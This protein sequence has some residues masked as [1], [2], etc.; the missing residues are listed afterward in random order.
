MDENL[1]FNSVLMFVKWLVWQMAFPGLVC[2]RQWL[3]DFL[4]TS[5]YDRSV[6]M[7]ILNAGVI[8][9]VW[10]IVIEIQYMSFQD[11]ANEGRN[12]VRARWL[13]GCRT[14]N[15]DRHRTRGSSDRE[16]CEKCREQ[17]H[18]IEVW[19]AIKNN[20]LMTTGNAE[21]D[22]RLDKDCLAR[23]D[24]GKTVEFF[25]SL[26]IKEMTSQVISELIDVGARG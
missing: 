6:A 10:D 12:A 13:P 17:S 16:P 19:K 4:C 2:D 18:P 21:E 1:L 25:L 22:A 11:G 5:G 7:A 15:M 14:S 24:A 26:N 23:I 3:H 8:Y 20:L 9:G